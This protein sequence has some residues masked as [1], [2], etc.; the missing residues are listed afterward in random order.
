MKE[1]KRNTLNGILGTIIFHLVIV[2]FFLIFKLGDV[3]K[4]HVETMKIEFLNDMVKLNEYLAK[5]EPP[6][7]DIQPLD[8]K[9]T[10]NI[11]VNV[12]NKLE[13]E[14][15]TEKY[16]EEVKKELGI[17]DLKQELDRK[18]PE[19]NS[20]KFIEKQNKEL[21]QEELKKNSYK[22]KTRITVNLPNRRIRHQDVP[23]YKCEIGGI[24]IVNIV[25]DQEGRVINANQS[26]ASG[27]KD[28][29]LVDEAINS[30]Y[31]F[32]FSADFNGESRQRGTITFEFLSQ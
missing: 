18:I 11:A 2:L 5:K 3:K 27:T 8:D 31:Q 26:E 16:E 13:K 32:L 10:K 1:G 7:A 29:C 22:G 4:K 17:K 25:V 23:V 21:K 15:S 9:T 20:P 6:P 12:A 30:A 28:E 24:V 14:I 19:D